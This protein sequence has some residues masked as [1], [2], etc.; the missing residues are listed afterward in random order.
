MRWR[1]SKRNEI[2]VS[3]RKVT[4][5][6]IGTAAIWIGDYSNRIAALS[7]ITHEPVSAFIQPPA[8]SKA[9]LWRSNS[10]AVQGNHDHAAEKE[11]G[12][13]GG[14]GGGLGPRANSWREPYKPS[15]PVRSALV[16]GLQPPSPPSLPAPGGGLMGNGRGRGTA[17]QH[18]KLSPLR[19]CSHHGTDPFDCKLGG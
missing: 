3:L 9:Q 11:H 4:C 12:G 10:H 8:G 6:A 13:G 15:G 19:P 5:I 17:C 7:G 18:V 2:L 16:D 14:G 1:A